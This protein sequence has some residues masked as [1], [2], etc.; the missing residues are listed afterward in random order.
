MVPSSRRIR[1]PAVEEQMVQQHIIPPEAA[2][3]VDNGCIAARVACCCA[4]TARIGGRLWDN[5]LQIL[6]GKSRQ[7][8]IH[9]GVKI[10]FNLLA[11]P[12]GERRLA[13]ICGKS[14]ASAHQ[15][16]RGQEHMGRQC[17]TQRGGQH[18][19]GKPH[20]S[21]RRFTGISGAAGQSRMGLVNLW[22][23]GQSVFFLMIHRFIL[24]SPHRRIRSGSS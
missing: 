16:T 4:R 12:L 24:L 2:P 9:A 8:P 10:C 17:H 20:S 14:V 18:L 13:C 5:P 23:G 6:V 22:N 21:V 7:T 11:G 3:L 19:H 15:Q 1:A